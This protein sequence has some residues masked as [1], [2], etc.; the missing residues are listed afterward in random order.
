MVG[1][2]NQ[3][4]QD[5]RPCRRAV[6]LRR[7]PRDVRAK[8]VDARKLSLP[9]AIACVRGAMRSVCPRVPSD[10]EMKNSR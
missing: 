10:N 3:I 8:P 5:R 6:S 2:E 7:M 9:L 4:V 1:G